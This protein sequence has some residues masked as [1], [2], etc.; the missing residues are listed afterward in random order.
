MGKREKEIGLEEWAPGVYV[1][2]LYEFENGML[3]GRLQL[4]RSA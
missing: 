1:F 3:I 2:V 4:S